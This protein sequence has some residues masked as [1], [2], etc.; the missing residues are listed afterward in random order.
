MGLLSVVVPVKDERDNVRP[1]FDRVRAA[2]DGAGTGPW[3]LVFVDDGSADDTFALLEAVSRGDARVKVVRLRRNF[4]QSAATQAGIDAATGDVIVT[5]DGD[6]QNDPADIP[7]MLAKLDEGYDAVLGQRQKRQ[8][9]L[10]LRKVPSFVANWF[11]RKVLGVPFKD[12]GCTLRAVR[13]EVFDGLVLYGEMH[14][15]I[16]ALIMLQGAKVTQVPVRH[17]PRTA[18]QS[19]YNLT[20]SVRVMLDLMT[21][22]F[23]GSFQTRPMH[24]FGGLGL[25]CMFAGFVSV[26]ASV[27][28]KY[29]TGPGMTQNPLFLLGAVASLIGV[30]FV[31]LG[32]MGEVLTRVYYESQGKRPYVVRERRNLDRGPLPSGRIAA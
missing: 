30:Q 22:K 19:K 32:L 3:E 11:I 7:L 6:L 5:M 21:V 26:A 12:F 15:F 18:G 1:M 14:R 31:S 9:K 10:L 17:H 4:G 16:T 2:L 25:L 28:I 29:T 8:D 23:Q 13:R 24:L 27:V 20:R